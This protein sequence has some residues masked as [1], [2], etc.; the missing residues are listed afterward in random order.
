MAESIVV[1]GRLVSPTTVELESPVDVLP[2]Q[3]RVDV[4]LPAASIDGEAQR[5]KTMKLIEHLRSLPPGN[6]TREDIER[7]IQEERDNWE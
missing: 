1:K 4:V 2:G 6:R 3:A 5:Q 7:Q